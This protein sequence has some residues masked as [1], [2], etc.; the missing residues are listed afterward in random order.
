[1]SIAKA[2]TLLAKFHALSNAAQMIGSHGEEGFC[3]DDKKFDKAYHNAVKN[4]SKKFDKQAGMYLKK[5]KV[6]GFEID[7]AHDEY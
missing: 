2:R 6:L 4:L 3:Y 5:Y 7:D 1:M